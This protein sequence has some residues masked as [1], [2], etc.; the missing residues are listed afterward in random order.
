MFTLLVVGASSDMTTDEEGTSRFKEAVTKN[1]QQHI[2]GSPVQSV[3]IDVVEVTH[4]KKNVSQLS[5]FQAGNLRW[6]KF[7]D[8]ATFEV[9]GAGKDAGM[10]ISVNYLKSH[11][12]ALVQMEWHES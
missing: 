5:L 2:M 7:T 8:Q 3:Q 10:T 4:F 1:F 9:S 11:P 12:Q 6:Q